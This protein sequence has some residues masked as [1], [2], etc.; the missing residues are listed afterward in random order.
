MQSIT[1]IMSVRE[2]NEKLELPTEMEVGIIINCLPSFD[3]DLI[4]VT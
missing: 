4:N 2:N 3:P 1:S